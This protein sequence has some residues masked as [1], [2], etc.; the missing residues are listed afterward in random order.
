MSKGIV[1]GGAFEAAVRHAVI[2]AWV[3]ADAVLFP[4]RLFYQRPVGRRVALVS[5]Q[6]T[7]SLPTEHVV[8][9]IAPRRA[10]IGLIAGKE[11]QE[12]TGM[13]EGPGASAPAPE[14]LTEQ[15]LT[16]GAA[17]K[18]ILLWRVL[19]AVS[20]GNRDAFDAKLH[21]L[22][23]EI[24]YAVGVFAHKQ[25]AVDRYAKAFAARKPDCRDRL[26]IDSLLADRLIVPLPIAVQMDRKCQVR[27]RLVFVNVLGEQ[28]RIGAQ[29]DEF[30]A[31]HDAGD[32]LRH[33]LMN[34]WLAAWNGYDGRATFV[35]RAQCV[36][37]THAL[38][39]N[40]LGV[41]DLPAPGAGE[42]ALKQRLEHQN[43]RVALD[44]AQL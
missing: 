36:F 41:I 7:G 44:A 9:G 24:S 40:L 20:R 32:D 43:Q 13:I 3:A 21:R 34:Q 19:I 10:L 37:Q 4:L 26:V 23:K 42:I 16:G 39:E 12:Q 5:E 6:I 38:L 30:L 11:I 25:R 31:C 15:P 8:G 33:F 28:N 22:I 1:D 29:V 14:D 2:A 27:R 18:H 35:H 17:E